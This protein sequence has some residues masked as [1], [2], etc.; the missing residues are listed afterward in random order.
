MSEAIHILLVDDAESDSSFVQAFCLKARDF[1]MKISH[2]NRGKRGIDELM[3]NPYKY[4]GIVLD[5]RCIWDDAQQFPND[6]F[7][8]RM[9]AELERAEKELNQSFPAVVNTAY[10]EDFQDELELI[11]NRGGEIFFKS[12]DSSDTDEQIFRFLTER[13]S[14]SDEWTYRDLFRLFDD[15]QLPSELRTD[16][17]SVIRNLNDPANVKDNFTGVRKLIEAIYLELKKL[18]DTLLPDV[19][20]FKRGSQINPKWCWRY[21]S[22][23]DVR[24]PGTQDVFHS[25][26][27]FPEHISKCVGSCEELTSVVSHLYAPTV[28]SYA[29]KSAAFNLFETMSWYRDY[30]TEKIDR[31]NRILK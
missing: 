18:D 3:L 8:T 25:Q 17:K 4:R 13:I 6:K 30:V 7:L 27:V 16:L 1:G 21:L 15:G 28:R 11:R 31:T 22:G 12:T 14:N 2:F 29:Y 10:I 5:A 19:A 24:I 26:A 23:M 9:V 20:M